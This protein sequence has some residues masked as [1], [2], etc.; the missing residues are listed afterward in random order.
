MVSQRDAKGQTTTMTYDVLGRMITKTDGDGTAQWVYDTSPVGKGIGKLAAMVS[1]P[2]NSRLKG[3]CS[4]RGSDRTDGKRVGR[5]FN[6]TGNGQLDEVFEC[7]D[8]ETFSTQY[9]Y[10]QFG[11]Q[12]LVR[13]PEVR[14]NRLA[15]EYHYASTGPATAG[16]LE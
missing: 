14:D 3:S 10:D 15:V 16:S 9:G 7:V 2:D 5:W 8:G 11:R 1:A 12:N 13:Y 6:Y 4:I